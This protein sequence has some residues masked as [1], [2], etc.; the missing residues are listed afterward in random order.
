MTT[1]CVYAYLRENGTPYYIGMGKPE[2]PYAQHKRGMLDMRPTDRTR[3]VI[4]DRDLTRNQALDKEK[5]EIAK[6]GLRENGGLLHNL[7]T[8]GECPRLSEETK[9]KMSHASLGKTKNPDSIRKMVLVRKERG[10]YSFSD[11]HRQKLSRVHKGLYSGAKNPRARPVIAY[12]LSGNMVGTY[13]TGREAAVNLKISWHHIP[14]V[15]KGRR[16]H[17]HGYVFRYSEERP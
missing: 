12:D 15:C 17:T 4:I 16:P 8:G 3:I 11:E 10:S 14:A 2:R 13:S 9:Q 1:Y 6:Y 7:T 5:H